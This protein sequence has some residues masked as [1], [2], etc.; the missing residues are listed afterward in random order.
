MQQKPFA[1]YAVTSIFTGITL[2]ISVAYLY[3]SLFCGRGSGC[4]ESPLT[5]VFIA[6]L[7]LVSVL[8][9]ANISRKISD[10]SS[11]YRIIFFSLLFIVPLLY[12]GPYIY[13]DYILPVFFGY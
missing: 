8:I 12:C 3:L 10:K 6:V 2:H 13:K 5:L 11:S 9:V 1:W 7:I 4:M